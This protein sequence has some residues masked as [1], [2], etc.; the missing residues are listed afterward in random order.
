MRRLRGR[1]TRDKSWRATSVCDVVTG[2][3]GRGGQGVKNKGLLSF[4]DD[5][6]ENE[7]S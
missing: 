2:R 7:A 1:G 6:A 3:V 5:D 4:N